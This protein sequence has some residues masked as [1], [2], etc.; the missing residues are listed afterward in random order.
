MIAA[1]NGCHKCLSIL[2][3]HG[4]AVDKTNNVSVRGVC[5]VAYLLGVVLESLLKGCM[6]NFVT[7]AF[8]FSMA[9]QLS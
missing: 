6:V 3:A 9:P 5:S 7:S 2:L 8:N 4:A 1:N